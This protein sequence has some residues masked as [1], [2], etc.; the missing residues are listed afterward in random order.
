[1]SAT[2]QP[3]V[4]IPFAERTRRK[5]TRRLIP[6][7]FI[8]YIISYLDRVNLSYAG[9][10]MTKELGFSNS[11]YG[12]GSGIFFLGYF[13]L[14][15]PGTIL[16]ELWSARKWI[17]RIMITWGIVAG[18]TGLI[19]NQTEFYGAR[20]LLGVAEAGFFPG[21]IVYLT[22]WFRAADRAKAMAGFMAAIP[23]SQIIGSPLSAALMKIHWLG[24]SGWR[25]LL[26]LEG[27]PAVIFGVIT[28]YYLTDRPK[29]AKWLTEEERNWI[30]SE[31]EAEKK[32]IQGKEKVSVWKAFLHRDVLIL[33]AVYFF[34][35][36]VSYGFTLWLPKMM[37]KLSGY[38]ALETT[39]IS[40]IPFIAAWP[41]MIAIGWSSDRTHERRW[42]TCASLVLAALGLGVARVTDSV[43]I[44]LAAFTVAAMGIN[45][46]M[47]P[48]WSMPNAFLAG[49]SAAAV[50]GSINSVGNLGGFVG[51]YLVGWLTD[52]TKNY[53]A[54]VL[55]LIGSALMAAV[56][57]LF[58]KPRKRPAS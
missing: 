54:G 33:T 31:L 24:Y 15:I 20:F 8:L 7:L 27:L 5:I 21:V 41:F 52:R 50:I 25:W 23:V 38:G 11:V 32:A 39:L 47:P 35:T 28:L 34:G 51:P 56:L 26:I 1:M 55:Y 49:T 40:A 30:D 22:H 57:V 4:P 3:L 45:G 58:V 43:P 48:F 17:A 29:D 2:N 9:L 14:E 18:L 42:H 16:V 13:L 6:F 53:Q 10:D 44:G 36:N 37:Q 12:L 46:R 19:H